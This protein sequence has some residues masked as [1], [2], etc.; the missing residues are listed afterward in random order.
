MFEYMRLFYIVHFPREISLATIVYLVYI[1][2]FCFANY[3]FRDKVV[4]PEIMFN[5]KIVVLLP[6]FQIK[7]QLARNRN[8]NHMNFSVM[9]FFPF[10]MYFFIKIIFQ[11]SIGR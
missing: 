11:I 5:F 1:G 9:M 6:S 4:M 7:I 2:Y 8:T 3:I 10:V